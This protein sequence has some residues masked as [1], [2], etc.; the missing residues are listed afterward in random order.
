MEAIWEH[1]PSVAPRSQTPEGIFMWWLSLVVI[2]IVF[3]LLS[4]PSLWCL[5]RYTRHML[6]D[7]ASYDFHATSEKPVPQPP[8]LVIT[9]LRR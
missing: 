6:R 2:G 5:P 7:P 4:L 1:A 8:L 3:F 9:R